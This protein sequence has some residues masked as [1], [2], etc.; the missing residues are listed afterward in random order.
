MAEFVGHDLD[1]VSRGCVFTLL[2]RPV[3]MIRPL[4][5]EASAFSP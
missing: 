5:S 3:T 2:E 1:N 4:R